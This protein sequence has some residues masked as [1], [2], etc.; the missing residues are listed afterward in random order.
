MRSGTGDAL[1]A[2]LHP[3]ISL[4][5]D[6]G[7]HVLQERARGGD[8]SEAAGLVFF[9]FLFLFPFPFFFPGDKGYPSNVLQ[10]KGA[11]E[12]PDSCV[13]ID[14]PPSLSPLLPS[15]TKILHRIRR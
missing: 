9:S 4:G 12:L 5:F 1:S 3:E 11:S 14:H 8:R 6:S 2:Y 10:D 7:P 15:L 13:V